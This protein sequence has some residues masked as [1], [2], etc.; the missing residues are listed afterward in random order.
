[1]TADYPSELDQSKEL[2]PDQATYFA[3][4]IGVFWWCIE[5]R[6]LD[7]I[8]EVSL[9]SCFLACP[10]E[11]HLQQAFHGFGYLKEHARSWMVFR[12]EMVPAINQSH[13]R[14]VD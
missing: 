6:W 11:G 10:C 12:H 14:V 9:L 2:G 3:G 1:M 8:V 7:I 5:F 13:F 4:H